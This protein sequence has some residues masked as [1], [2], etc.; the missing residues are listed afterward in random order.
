MN[1]MFPSPYCAIKIAFFMDIT[2]YPY[3]NFYLARWLPFNVA[4]FMLFTLY[5]AINQCL[6]LQV[7]SSKYTIKFTFKNL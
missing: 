7:S 3:Y 4:I 2:I 5:L 6:G 1:A